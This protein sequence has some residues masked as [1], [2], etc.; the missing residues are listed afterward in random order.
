MAAI[1]NA[2]SSF[3]LAPAEDVWRRP[4]EKDRRQARLLTRIFCTDQAATPPESLGRLKELGSG[5]RFF[6]ETKPQSPLETGAE[7]R[8]IPCEFVYSVRIR[9]RRSWHTNFVTSVAFSSDGKRIA[10]GSWDKSVKVW[11]TTSGEVRFDLIGRTNQVT[12]VVFS[13]DGKRI[14]SGSLDSTVKVWDATSGQEALTLRRPTF[15]GFWSGGGV[16]FSPDGKR[17]ASVF[18]D[19]TVIVWD[20]FSG[21]E[22]LTLKGPTERFTHY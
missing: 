21:H 22:T 8:T 20:A 9:T 17:I 19:S 18:D 11:D 2:P 4:R 13:P 5:S 1:K 14:A 6:F 10:S 3:V 7:W 16:A 15:G 12:G